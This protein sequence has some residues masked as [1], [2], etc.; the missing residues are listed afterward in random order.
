MLARFI[1]GAGT[2]HVAIVL[3]D[4]EVDRPR[5]Q[6]LDHRFIGRPETGFGVAGL[7]EGILRGV[8]AEQVEVGM[9]E[10]ALEAERPR[11]IDRLQK[12]EHILPGMHPRPADFSLGSQPLAM[13]GRHDRRFAE[14][15]RDPLRVGP[16]MLTPRVDAKLGRVDADDAILPH[17]M[18]VENLGD[19][20]GLTNRVDKL[21]PLHRGSHGRVAHRARPDWRHE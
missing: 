14:G 18:L 10:I 4:V 13:A 17:A 5:P 3:G 7:E 9:G 8:V 19:A 1:V 11:H 6:F 15:G 12:V 16:S 2:M 21:A 20:A